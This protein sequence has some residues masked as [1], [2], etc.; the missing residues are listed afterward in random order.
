[1]PTLRPTLVAMMVSSLLLPSVTVA[2]APADA[3]VA[4]LEEVVVTARKREESIQDVPLSVE[5]FTSE[6]L[7]RRGIQELKDVSLFTPGFSFESYNSGLASP[8]IRGATQQNINALEQNVSTFIDGV[9]LPRGYVADL[10]LK[11]VARIE[12]IK[13]P[14]SAR[15]GRN[16]FMGAINYVPARPGDELEL[17]AT[18]GAGSDE[19]REGTVVIG[20]P[21]VEGLLR[22]RGSYSKSEFDGTIR[23]T[24]PFSGNVPRPG[25]E[26]NLGGYDREQYSLMLAFTPTETI[27]LEAAW[28]HFDYEDEATPTYLFGNANGVSPVTNTNCGS[29]LLGFR[30]FCGTLPAARAL[31][32]DPRAYGRQ[33]K[34]DVYRVGAEIALGERF[35]ANYILGRV[36]AE[37]FQIGYSDSNSATCPFFGPGCAFQNVPLG[38]L[39]Y[40]SHE[41]RLAYDAGGM[42]RASLGVYL[43]DGDD[44]NLFTFAAAVPPVGAPITT[45][46]VPFGAG[47]ILAGNTTTLTEDTSYFGDVTLSLIGGRMRLGAEVRRGTEEKTQ[48][49]NSS[50]QSFDSKF[51]TTTPRVTAEYDLAADNLLYA[52]AA[53]GTRSGGFNVTAGLAEAFR[54]YRP[55]SNWTY[56]IGSKNTFL[57]RRLQ[58]NGALFYVDAKDTQIS[59]LPPNAAPG[60]FAILLNLGSYTSKGFELSLTARPAERWAI[61]AGLAFTDAEYDQARDIRFI[62]P[63]TVPVG[64]TPVCPANGDLAGRQLPRQSPWSG[65]TGLQYD[66]DLPFG[67]GWKG[68]ARADI[69]YQSSQYVDQMNLAEVASRTLVNASLGAQG[70]RFGATVWARNLLDEN[71]VAGSFFVPGS[72]TSYAPII[73]A[74][75]TVGATV[76]FRY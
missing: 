11:D 38:E 23:N 71:Y 66:A 26:G 41:L 52:S 2:Q 34:A 15:Y 5:A 13:G 67:E 65:T 45:P 76:T 43:N 8:V 29:S 21:V 59:S 6:E 61:N 16:A 73:G 4:M 40:D 46:L 36:E 62:A 58:I 64:V 32:Y 56:E 33:M 25:T 24:N 75:R 42:L 20:G 74:A 30:L 7:Q 10:A 35:T 60:A 18:L 69:A 31:D 49:N 27:Q 22:A 28:Y 12:V 39:K 63:C 51:T 47:W 50:G 54:V 9:Y 57:D 44:L 3:G 68:Y 1:M 70:R 55:E 37:T 14:Q 19:L 53:K 48:R 17:A 72:T